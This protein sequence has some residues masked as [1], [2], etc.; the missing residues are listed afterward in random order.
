MD[1]IDRNNR[2]SLAEN[3]P[4]AI[5]RP[6]HPATMER[7]FTVTNAFAGHQAA[8]RQPSRAIPADRRI[9]LSGGII[10]HSLQTITV[11]H[12]APAV[13]TAAVTEEA[14]MGPSLGIR[15]KW[16]AT[17]STTIGKLSIDVV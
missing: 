14:P 10:F 7:N 13:D 16:P 4:E 1:S 9:V 12:K 2:R 5:K 17:A 8:A 11:E 15:S 3:S 6:R